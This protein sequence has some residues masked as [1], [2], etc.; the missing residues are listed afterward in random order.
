MLRGSQICCSWKE[1]AEGEAAKADFTGQEPVGQCPKCRGRVFETPRVYTCENSVGAA[2][3][4]DFRSGKVIL[5][6]TI[7]RA[8]MQKL[9]AAGKTDLLE[10]FTSRKGRLFKAYL[11]LKEG[12]VEFEFEPRAAK[13][14][15]RAAKPAPA[16]SQRPTFAYSNIGTPALDTPANPG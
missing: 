15:A 10:K 4:C 7:E 16:A 3:T 2:R 5:Q 12:R 13:S 6:R 14:R 8:Q 11:V 9:L 1:D